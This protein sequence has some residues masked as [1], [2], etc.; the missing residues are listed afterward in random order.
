MAIS[1]SAYSFWILAPMVF[2]SRTATFSPS[3][4]MASSRCSVPVSF[5][6]N[7]SACL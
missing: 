1:V 6:P 3:R 4:M 2:R 5:W 7:R